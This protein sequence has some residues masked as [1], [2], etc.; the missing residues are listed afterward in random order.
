ME[1]IEPL[2]FLLGGILAIVDGYDVGPLNQVAL[3]ITT[4][5]DS[6]CP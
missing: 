5:H 2:G 3:K 6:D 1:V 4:M